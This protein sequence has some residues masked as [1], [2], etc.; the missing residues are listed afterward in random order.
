MDGNNVDLSWSMGNSLK[1]NNTT[2]IDEIR[3]SQ[4]ENFLII[5][6]MPGIS[7][8]ELRSIKFFN[9]RR[10]GYSEPIVRDITTLIGGMHCRRMATGQE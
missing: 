5:M 9:E 7:I 10:K 1:K 8:G 2:P 4:I 6:S 3:K